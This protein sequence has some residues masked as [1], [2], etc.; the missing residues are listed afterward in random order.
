LRLAQ[1]THIVERVTNKPAKPAQ[2]GADQPLVALAQ[3]YTMPNISN[4]APMDCWWDWEQGLTRFEWTSK[5][6][7]TKLID[8][9]K[10]RFKARHFFVDTAQIPWAVQDIANDVNHYL[11]T[12]PALLRAEYDKVGV[13]TELVRRAI[14]EDNKAHYINGSTPIPKFKRIYV[15]AVE[16]WLI[17]LRYVNSLLYPSLDPVTN[18]SYWETNRGKDGIALLIISALE[19]TPMKMTS[20]CIADEV[21]KSSWLSP[22]IMDI[23]HMAI[24]PSYDMID[25][26]LNDP[27]NTR[28]V[29]QRSNSGHCLWTMRGDL[30]RL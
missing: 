25:A 1:G 27:L 17:E 2:E 8:T 30:R 18:L 20:L 9:A 29:K 28:F 11:N 21:R 13:S 14:Q 4:L 6:G 26:V 15:G 24:M 16:H 23:H 12:E 22:W 19:K 5:R 7:I 10:K 3:A